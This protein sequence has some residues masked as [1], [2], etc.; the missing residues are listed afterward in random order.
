M[1][2]VGGRLGLHR[3]KEQQR[4]AHYMTPSFAITGLH[5][6]LFFIIIIIII[7]VVIMHSVFGQK[8]SPLSNL[9]L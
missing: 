3:W 1:E 6:L 9:T 7:V 5:K 8:H 2:D 4:G